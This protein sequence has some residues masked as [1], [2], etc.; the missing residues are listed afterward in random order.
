MKIIV[1]IE[2]ITLSMVAML[3]KIIIS[4]D[5]FTISNSCQPKEDKI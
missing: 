3:V 2:M 4:F 1:I 5:E